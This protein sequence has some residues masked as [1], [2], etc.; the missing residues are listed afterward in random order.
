MTAVR[1]ARLSRF[2]RPASVSFTAGV[3]MGA[4]CWALGLTAPAPTLLGPA[5]L[6]GVAIGG[7]AA[8]RSAPCC[9]VAAPVPAPRSRPPPE[10]SSLERKRHPCR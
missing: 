9:P 3:A 10:D 5:G 1:R 4:A 7:R 8:R 2:A 6:L